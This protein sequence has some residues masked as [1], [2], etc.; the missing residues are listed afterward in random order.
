MLRYDNLS[1][2]PLADNLAH[3]FIG[4]EALGL[5]PMTF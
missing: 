3:H 5:E 4:A 2:G 1:A